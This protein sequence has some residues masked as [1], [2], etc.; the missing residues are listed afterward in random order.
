MANK[1]LKIIIIN[2]NNLKKLPVVIII[3]N[4]ITMC[5]G[6][7]KIYAT[8][9]QTYPITWPNSQDKTEVLSVF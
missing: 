7:L 2:M 9:T 6:K 1:K 8:S 5:L 3:K 4:S